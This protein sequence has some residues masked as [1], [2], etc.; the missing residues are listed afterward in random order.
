MLEIS[1]TYPDKPGETEVFHGCGPTWALD[2]RPC[3]VLAY[4]SHRRGYVVEPGNTSDEAFYGTKD[5]ELVL[6]GEGKRVAQSN[7]LWEK[8]RRSETD[9]DAARDV[10]DAMT[11][12]M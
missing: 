6:D 11:P 10:F 12:L 7:G 1:K 8:A 3:Q 5:G 4:T 9:E 2:G